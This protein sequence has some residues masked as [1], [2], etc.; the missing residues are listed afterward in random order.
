MFLVLGLASAAPALNAQERAPSARDSTMRPSN[1]V[2]RVSK[3]ITLAGAAGAAA[4]GI[5]A[6]RDADQR[7]SDIERVC[8]TT[9]ERC[10]S[11]TSSGAF[12]DAELE[13]QYQ[14]VLGLDRR[15]KTALIA[16]EVSVATSIV[17]FIVDL[18]RNNRGEDIPYH[19]PR[20]E[21]RNSG[22]R[23][24]LSYRLPL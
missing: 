9:P 10:R 16:A 20:L 23:L 8:L 15:A 22:S 11:R 13:Q 3:W 7:Y 19:P 6:N 5:N 17:L 1:P 18:P 2:V 4:W 14:D 12:S 21:I 24:Q